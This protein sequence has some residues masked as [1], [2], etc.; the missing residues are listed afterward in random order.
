MRNR[1]GIGWVITSLVCTGLGAI[2]F[3]IGLFIKLMPITAETFNYTVNGVRQPYT[4]ANV[5]GM[6]NLFFGIFGGV[7]G[8][9]LLIGLGLG[10]VLI[11]AIRSLRHQ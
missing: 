10:V 2:F 11:L 9:L 7:G 4:Q 3:A 6:R 8:V 5:A 1:R